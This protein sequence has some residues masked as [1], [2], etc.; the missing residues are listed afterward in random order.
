[1]TP[2]VAHINLLRRGA[3]VHLVSLSLAAILAVTLV[4]L[5]VRGGGVLTDAAAVGAER[6]TAAQQL[7]QLRAQVVAAN[8]ER[9]RNAGA[10]ALRKEIEALQPQAV[11]AQALIEALQGAEGGRAERFNQALD[12]LGRTAEPGLWLSAVTIAASGRQLEISGGARSGAV[13]LRFAQRVNDALRPQ[14]L[15]LDG[16]EIQ[17]AAPAVAPGATAAPA[18]GSDVTFRMF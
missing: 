16:L 1:M 6:D 5:V 11:V 9:A 12:T 3:P 7:G 15:R 4:G 8:D 18:A 14:G 17:P 2:V 10:L 13:V